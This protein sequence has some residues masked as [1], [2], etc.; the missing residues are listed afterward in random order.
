MQNVLPAGAPFTGPALASQA[1]LSRFENA[2][3]SVA[4]TTLGHAL[5]DL[6]IE[7]HRARRQGRARRITI[8]LDPTDD[9]PHGQQ[10]LTFFNGHYDTWSYLPLLGLESCAT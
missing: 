1:T 2:V 4:L 10:Q 6:V 9:P 7:Q 5:A 8:D 3:G